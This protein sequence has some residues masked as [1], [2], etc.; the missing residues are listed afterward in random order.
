MLLRQ[1]ARNVREYGWWT[2]LTKSGKCPISPP[3]EA[4]RRSSFPRVLML[5]ENACYPHDSRVRREART[6]VAAGCAVSVICPAQKGQPWREVIDGVHLYQFP[7]LADGDGLLGYLCEYGYA[8]IAA[9]VL[10]LVVLFR[11]GFDVVHAHNP[12]DL[13]VLIGIFYKLLGKR[14][15]F[16]HHDL[17]PEMY[18]ARFPGRGNRLVHRALLFFERLSCRMA[19][20]VIATNNSYKALEQE[21]NGTPADR[22]TVVRNGPEPA[23]FQDA[24]PDLQLRRKAG[25]I[26][27]Y[28]GLMNVQ[29][30]IDYL[31][32]AIKHLVDD[33]GRT[34][35]YCVLVGAGA[36]W[37]SLRR[38]SGQLGLDKYV[39]F[40]GY[41][42]FRELRSYLA[43]AD[44]FVAPDPKNDFADRSTMLKLM[45]YMTLGKPIVAFD[46]TEHRVTAQGAALYAR[47]NDELD[48]ARKIA[49]LMDDPELRA[50]MGCCGQQRVA[51][52]LAWTYQAP[53]LL[54][55]Y[56]KVTGRALTTGVALP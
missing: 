11:R 20:R 15:V 7:S 4:K 19:D 16:D 5:L 47:A 46:L 42:P 39:W 17:A 22:I 13:F 49:V 14:F 34:D 48:F 32:R 37:E 12:P 23:L 41:V 43:T 26:I 21:R 28:V 52:E 30:G 38:L 9:S 24:L 44:I 1:F 53:H 56:A 8:M 45:E 6:L 33:L 51:T 54:D 27:G 29:D 2:A 10:S 36:A 18:Y 55:A 40:T 50:R 31:L 3:P 25:T 35:V